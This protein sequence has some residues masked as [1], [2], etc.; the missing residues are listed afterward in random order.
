M[1]SILFLIGVMP[2]VSAFLLWLFYLSLTVVGQDFL[3]FQWDNLLLE[4]GFLLIFLL[5]HPFRIHFKPSVRPSIIIIW[6]FRWL[7]FRLMFESGMVKL[8]S[9]D[10]NWAHLTALTY[11]YWT[12]P[13]PNMI[14]WYANQLP[15][16][17][18]KLCC[19]LMFG[20]EIFMPFFIFC[21]RWGRLIAFFGITG[22]QL[23][24]I[25]TGNY[26]FFNLLAI[27]L[28]LT[29]LEDEHLFCRSYFR[30]ITVRKR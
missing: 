9:G 28:C 1:L 5:P 13:L 12:Q 29:L 27:G 14:S 7:L 4:A 11:H 8:L 16:W 26:C 24:I 23:L 3:G 20:I 25:L 18:Q 30:V 10:I 22:L 6:L 19:A 21:G 15:L 2:A 17:F